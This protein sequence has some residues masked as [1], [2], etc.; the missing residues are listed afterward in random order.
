MTEDI[1]T[2]SRLYFTGSENGTVFTDEISENIWTANGSVTTRG[3]LSYFYNSPPTGGQFLGPQYSTSSWIDAPQ[4]TNFDLGAN[5]FTIDLWVNPVLAANGQVCY[6]AGKTTSTISAAT[7]SYYIVRN[8]SNQVSLYVS[9]GGS[10]YSVETNTTFSGG[11]T[12]TFVRDATHLMVYVN[13]IINNETTIPS[14]AVN[15]ISSKF[16]IGR[17]GEYVSNSYDGYLDDFR[18]SVGIARRSRYSQS[19]I[20]KITITSEA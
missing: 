6:I 20:P 4:S 8:S 1:Y 10:V 2:K 14:G 13:N 12:L 19:F 17:A 16:S 11:K 9:I 15:T 3:S 18:L 5:N 7:S